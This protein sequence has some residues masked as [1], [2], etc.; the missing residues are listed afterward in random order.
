MNDVQLPFLQHY[1]INALR[2]L[3]ALA[4]CLLAVTAAP[5]PLPVASLLFEVFGTLAIFVAIAGRGWALF[6]I[7]GRKNSE[8]VTFGPYSI[9]RN[10]LYVF[11]LIGI[12]G[13]G[14]QTDSLLSMVMFVVAAYLAFDMAMLGEEV[15]LA[16]RYGRSFEAYRRTVP[17]FWP[18]F[19]LWRECEGV[20]LRSA[21]ALGSLRDGIVFPVAWFAIELLRAGQDAGF[22]PV[23][24]TLPI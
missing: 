10:P 14:A 4:F 11:S 23:V 8:L 24:W 17:R 16:S 13:V 6:Y 3:G 7:G 2:A 5:P 9:T 1:R 12:A 20:P 19:S 21:S 22:L 18:D 15:Y